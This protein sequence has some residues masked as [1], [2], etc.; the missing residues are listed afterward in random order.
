[1]HMAAMLTPDLAFQLTVGF[2][3]HLNALKISH[4]FFGPRTCSL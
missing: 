1:M 2:N 4:P 3:L